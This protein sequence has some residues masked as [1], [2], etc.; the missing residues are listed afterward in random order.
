VRRAAITA[1][2]RLG[3]APRPEDRDTFRDA[4]KSA[5]SEFVD[6]AVGSTERPAAQGE[7]PIP[8]EKQPTTFR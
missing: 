7:F 6:A 8:A 2:G 5:D 4:L 3:I 1:I